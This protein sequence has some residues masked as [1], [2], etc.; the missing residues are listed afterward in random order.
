MTTTLPRRRIKPA[1]LIAAAGS[2]IG[3]GLL[4]ARPAAADHHDNPFAEVP[5]ELRV[6]LAKAYASPLG[7]TVMSYVRQ[8]KPNA[9]ELMDGLAE[10]LGMDLRTAVST[11]VVRGMI[12]STS[13][14]SRH[15]VDMSEYDLQIIADL[16]ETTGKLEG[17][18]L[19]LPGYDSDELDDQTLLHSFVIEDD[20]R[21][22]DHG[23]EV[24]ELEIE[25]EELQ[26]EVEVITRELRAAE[27]EEREELAVEL[28][29]LQRERDLIR[30]ELGEMLEDRRDEE[31]EEEGLFRVFVALPE[32]DGRFT[33]VA[34]LDDEAV[35]E[36]AEAV[37]E[38]ETLLDEDEALRGEEIAR[39]YL[40]D[41]SNHN[42][43][44]RV[45]GSAL[46]DS[47]AGLSLTLGSGRN[48]TAEMVM[49]TSSPARARQVSQLL[50]GLIAL[51][52][53]AAL[54]QPDIQE[55]ANTL[56]EIQITQL[57]D[58]EEPGVSARFSGSHA[59][60]EELLG[61]VLSN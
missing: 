11:V 23:D 48:I 18:M 46:L 38:G 56:Q 19:G 25:A 32:A 21:E 12:A 58:A 35:I 60:F 16:G 59:K 6:D 24:R 54:E 28:R 4:L 31:E 51:S 29:D 36:M 30:R 1:L 61:Y 20:S 57:D 34:A 42:L 26:H 10:T 37:R 53:L 50:Q 49:E 39:L 41:L 22:A 45:P 5:F 8:A 52:Q 43:P 27:D 13:S 55:L 2:M 17:W 7:E 47:V 9:D 15:A 33:L 3:A 44:R 14:P 40:D